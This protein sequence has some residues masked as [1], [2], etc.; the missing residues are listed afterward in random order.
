M[1]T[2]GLSHANLTHLL[3]LPI[4][5]GLAWKFSTNVR[6]LYILH[7]SLMSHETW[8]EYQVS[9]WVTVT[10]VTVTVVTQEVCLHIGGRLH[11]H[12]NSCFKNWCGIQGTD[13]SDMCKVSFLCVTHTHTL[14]Y[15]CWGLSRPSILK[16][17]KMCTFKP[18]LSYFGCSEHEFSIFP[19]NNSKLGKKKLPQS[20]DCF[21]SPLLQL[22]SQV[23]TTFVRPSVRPSVPNRN[24]QI[25]DTVLPR[26]LA[27][28]E[29][30]DEGA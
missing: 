11:P 20:P 17:S 24:F 25:K 13:I 27:E 2:H 22:L 23:L 26:R 19:Q 16:N 3:R 1:C 7:T 5:W 30:L 6:G 9:W 4:V 10:T 14:T 15:Y 28:F 12:P 18:I 21:S 29:S 8:D